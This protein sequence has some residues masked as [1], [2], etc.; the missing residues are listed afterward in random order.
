MA[1]ITLSATRKGNGNQATVTLP[2]GYSISSGETYPSIAEAVKPRTSGG[3]LGGS[4]R[5]LLQCRSRP[6]SSAHSRAVL[7]AI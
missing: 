6:H 3:A 4:A 7:G 5:T 2:D 1:T